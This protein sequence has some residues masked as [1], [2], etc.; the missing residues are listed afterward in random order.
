[1]QKEFDQFAAG[2]SEAFTG[3]ADN[4]DAEFVKWLDE[5][6]QEYEQ[7]TGKV[8]DPVPKP[9]Q[10]PVVENVVPG[11]VQNVVPDAVPRVIQTEEPQLNLLKP[12]PSATVEQGVEQ[13]ALSDKLHVEL[14]EPHTVEGNL[15][16]FGEVVYLPS[17]SVQLGPIDTHRSIAKQWKRLAQSDYQPLLIQIRQHRDEWQ[18]SD[19]SVLQL[20]AKQAE[21]LYSEKSQQSLYVWF[22][23]TKLGYAVRA[24][25]GD[26]D[27]QLLFAGQQQVYDRDYF[28]L[29]GQQY[30]LLEPVKTR[31]SFPR[32]Y[33]QEVKALD[34]QYGR[35]L[36]RS[37]KTKA[38]MIEVDNAA[39]QIIAV[40]PRQSL[41]GGYPQLDLRYYFQAP[42]AEVTGQS[43]IKALKPKLE[44]LNL[45]Q[46]ANWLLRW[47][48]LA[49]VYK[50]DG[51]QFGYENYLH[52]E[53]NFH[54][55]ANDCED[56]SFLYAWL[57]RNLIN[58][59]VVGVHYPGHV[60]TAIVLPEGAYPAL[61][62]SFYHNNQRYWVAD[63]TYIGA[64]VGEIMPQYRSIHPEFID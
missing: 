9:K 51:D 25:L 32:R 23:M 52:P 16:L 35:S 17:K 6:W 29:D 13:V 30:Y 44:G 45:L 34:L 20:V 15:D 47:V 26:S 54:F 8:R 10:A 48:Q 1:M 57:V 58:L 40:E 33:P 31:L 4:N 41:L 53:E 39:Y 24:G 49:F 27:L 63:P 42:V 22:V 38:R 55:S 36:E 18:L 3:F 7:F 60:A 50:V 64:R 14:Q 59:P 28:E 11:V 56:R 43:L 46:Q 12:L 5:Q 61:A 2:N 62:T 21:H 37:P 19:W